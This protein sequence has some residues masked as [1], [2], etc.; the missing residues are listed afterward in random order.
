MKTTFSASSGSR[1]SEELPSD[2]LK[3]GFEEE[4]FGEEGFEGEGV[5]SGVVTMINSWL[6][7]ESGFPR[8]IGEC[9]Y[10]AVEEVTTA[11]E[12]DR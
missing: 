5:L 10:L 4:G 2:L 12:N 11:V 7:L 9:F 1:L 6:E 8:R 3:D